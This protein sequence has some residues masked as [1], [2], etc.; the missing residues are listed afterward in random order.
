M[1]TPRP[2]YTPHLMAHRRGRLWRSLSV[3][4][5]AATCLPLAMA[6]TCQ[7]SAG[8]QPPAVV[9]LFTSQGCSSCP[10]AD[11]WLSTLKGN[12]GVI[13]LSFHVNYWNYLGWKDP[14]ATA[15]TTERQRQLQQAMKGAYVYTPQVVLNGRDHRQWREQGTHPLPRLP[16]TPQAP[17]LSL[18]RNGTQVTA[19]VG[20]LPGQGQLAGY[21]AVL[22]DGLSQQVTR[23]EN[24]G[25]RLVNDHVVSHYQPVPAW[26]ANSP[27]T[28]QLTVPAQSGKGRVVFIVTQPGYTQPVQGLALQ[29]S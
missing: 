19:Q 2:P 15:E 7:R 3:G 21:W 8:A 23:G 26:N 18:A 25:S 28:L 27:H 14:Y 12:E 9:E 1:P 22:S 5:L 29:C 17:T 13:A 20:A 4:A 6:Q 16:A 10:P 11:A 24:A